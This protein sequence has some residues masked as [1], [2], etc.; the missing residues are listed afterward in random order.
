M[1]VPQDAYMKTIY[2]IEQPAYTLRIGQ[3]NKAWDFFCK[4]HSIFLYH[5][6]TPFNPESELLQSDNNWER[7]YNFKND[8]L[9]KSIQYYNYRSIDPDQEWPDEHGLV[10]LNLHN[11]KASAYANEYSQNAIVRGELNMQ[12]DLQWLI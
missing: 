1:E 10:L 5:L 12:A 8:V 2:F 11:K 4:R 6:I 3:E 7:L 9:E